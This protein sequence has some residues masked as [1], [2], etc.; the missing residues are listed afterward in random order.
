V[1]RRVGG[2]LSSGGGPELLG[3]VCIRLAATAE[4]DLEVISVDTI[5]VRGMDEVARERPVAVTNT[6]REMS[7]RMME[8]PIGFVGLVLAGSGQDVLRRGQG[9]SSRQ[10]GWLG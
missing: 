7:R 6:L 4:D 5:E 2:R 1:R 9:L 3:G 8:V 10:R